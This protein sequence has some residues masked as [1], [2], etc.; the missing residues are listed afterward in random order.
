MVVARRILKGFG[1]KGRERNAGG[2]RGRG[3]RRAG[4]EAWFAANAPDVGAFV[5]E[6][7]PSGHSNLTYLVEGERRVRAA[8]SAAGS[9]EGRARHGARAPHPRGAHRVLFRRRGRS[10]SARTRRPRRAVLRDGARARRHPAPG[11]PAGSPVRRAMRGLGESFIDNAGGAALG[12]RVGPAL[13]DLGKPEGYVE[14]QVRGW[15]KRWQTRAPTTCRRWT[16]SREWLDAHQPQSS[17]A[18]P[19]P[20]RLQVRQPGAGAR[21]SVAHHRRARLGDVDRR[22]SAD[23]SGHGARLLGRGRAIIRRSGR[24]ASE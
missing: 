12:R 11:G 17:G 21:R 22:R 8:A 19:H 13:G 16:P 18:L 1:V 4:A 10:P 5:I 2:A 23:G 20:Q 9:G 24:S 3:A 15:A 7:F 6:Q 14:R